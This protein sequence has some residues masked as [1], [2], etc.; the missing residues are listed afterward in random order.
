MLQDQMMILPALRDLWQSPTATIMPTLLPVVL[1][2]CCM[3][4]EQHCFD[5]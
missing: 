2:A 3:L 4:S 1:P 5:E